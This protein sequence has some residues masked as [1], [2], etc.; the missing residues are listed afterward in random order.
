MIIV[1]TGDQ[2]V[3]V[4]RNG[5]EIGRARAS[6]SQVTPESQVLTLTPRKTGGSEWIQVG[7]NNLTGTAGAIISTE[8]VERMRIPHEFL[9]AMRSVMTPGTTVLVTQASVNADSTGGQTTVLASDA[10]AGKAP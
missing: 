6:V 9:T 5:V 7:V 3:V 8:G 4:L 1:S 2:M 10:N